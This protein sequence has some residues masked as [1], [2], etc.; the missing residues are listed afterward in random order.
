MESKYLKD[1][2]ENMIKLENFKKKIFVIGVVEDGIS[3]KKLNKEEKTEV[4]KNAMLIHKMIKEIK[5]ES[6][7]VEL[8]QDRYDEWYYDIISHPNYDH[9]LNNIHKVLDAGKYEKL[10]ENDKIDIDSGTLE[11]LIGMDICSYRMPCKTILGDRSISITSK[12]YKSKLN[13]IDVYKQA[14]V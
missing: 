10:V 12:R 7:V 13:M 1:S 8:C 2:Q 11:Y 6:V 14:A 4:A 5:P 3:D 9:T